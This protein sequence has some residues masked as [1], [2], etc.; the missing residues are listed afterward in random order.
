MVKT[1]GKRNRKPLIILVLL[2]IAA[3]VLL[4]RPGILRDRERSAPGREPA[5]EGQKIPEQSK[6]K[7][8]GPDSKPPEKTRVKLAV[9]IDDV[10]VTSPYIEGYRDFEG[11]LTFSVLPFQPESVNHART[12]HRAGFEIMI[13]IPMEPQDYPEKEP[14][15]GALFVQDSSDEVE[16]KLKKMIQNNPYASGAN[17]HMGSMATQDHELMTHTLSYLK[18]EGLYFVDSLT[19]SRSTAYKL[20][21]QLQMKSGD[22]DIF[23]D[24]HNDYTYI[25]N[26]F[27]QLKSIARKRGT[28]IG[29]GH[30]QNNYLLQVLNHQLETLHNEGFELVF[31]SE[32]I[33]N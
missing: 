22:R 9:I 21:R 15:E 17:N 1:T 13:H 10:G 31:A 6:L 24:N 4:F 12:L 20:A 5:K 7:P 30:I 28:A 26:Q 11:K 18:D 27:E 29:I 25:N 3:A 32:V 14:G 8:A 33:G 19:S 2:A 16:K 23:L